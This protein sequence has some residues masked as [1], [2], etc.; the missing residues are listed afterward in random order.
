MGTSVLVVDDDAEITSL[1]QEWLADEGYRSVAVA[2]AGEALERAAREPFDV[3][4]LDLVLPG[5]NGLSLAG[6]LRARD[7]ELPL[8]LVTGR[9]SFDVAI[10]AMRLGVMDYLLKPFGR[11]RFLN[12]VKRAELRR[13]A[14]LEARAERERLQEMVRQR[15]GQLTSAFGEIETTRAET[16]EA[17]LAT[18]NS[19]NPEACEHA[20][21]VAE[22]SVRLARLLGASEREVWDLERGALLHDIGK[23]AMPDS[24]MLKPGKL[25]A[26][27]REVVRTHPQIGHDIVAGVPALRAAADIVLCSHERYDGAGYPRAIAAA[28]IPLGARIVAVADTFDALT[29]ARVYRPA[30]PREVAME[31]MQRCAGSQFDPDVVRALV[32][33]EGAWPASMAS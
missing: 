22:L 28:D 6:R 2:S 23:I 20:R 8:L 7:G 32:E 1:Y 31:E 10:E 9:E 24:V 27:E 30:M 3:G 13:S 16:L 26:E 4:V 18:L 14:A 15:T 33:L 21:R 12:A 19:R 5:E 25:S 17:L 11:A 29:S